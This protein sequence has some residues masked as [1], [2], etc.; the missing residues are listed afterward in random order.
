MA[1]ASVRPFSEAAGRGIAWIAAQQRRDGSFCDLPDG[2]GGYYKVPYTLALAGRQREALRLLAWV[3]EHH[4]TVDGDFRA[5]ER[6]ALEPA[7]EAWPVYANAWLVQGACR[8]GRWDLGRRGAEFILRYQTPAGGFYALDGETRFLEPVCTSWGGLAVLTT[9][10]LQ[11][12]C[13][14]GDLL[15]NLAQAQP[16]PERFYFRMDPAGDLI[17][18]VPAGAALSHYVDATCSKQIYYN[19][20][21]ALIFLAHLYRATGQ[22][23]YLSAGREIFAFTERC[24]DDVHRFPPSGKLGLGAALMY[25]ITGSPEVRRAAVRVAEYLVETQTAEGFWRL[26]DEAVYAAIKDKDGFEVRLDLSAEFSAFLME[27]ASRV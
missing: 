15:A 5:P 27:T 2:V 7:H 8:V 24:A 11:A 9:G 20:G 18:D 14:A 19:P 16:D 17:T 3:A 26:P 10:H 13:R 21:I 22:E 25:E 1:D 4:F 6:K 12:A 23:R